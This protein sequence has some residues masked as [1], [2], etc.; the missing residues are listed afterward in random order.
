MGITQRLL[1]QRYG[2]LNIKTPNLD[3]IR[4][5]KVR[6]WNLRSDNSDYF[7]KVIYAMRFPPRRGPYYRYYIYTI[8]RFMQEYESASKNSKDQ[9]RTI[10]IDRHLAAKLLYMLMRPEQYHGFEHFKY[11]WLFDALCAMRT[12]TIGRMYFNGR[13]ETNN[14]TEQWSAGFEPWP[15]PLSQAAGAKLADKLYDIIHPRMEY[16]ANRSNIPKSDIYSQ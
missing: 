10:L 14:T 4:A 15:K 3:D 12:Y 2:E 5:A 1:R 8:N 13:I 6:T 11:S 7:D 16:I 9:I